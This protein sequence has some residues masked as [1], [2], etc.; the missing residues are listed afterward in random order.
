[1]GII[2][3]LRARAYIGEGNDKEKLEELRKHASV[4]YLI[5]KA[6]PIPTK[7][8]TNGQPIFLAAALP[9]I[10]RVELFEEAINFLQ[11]E[12]PA[13]TKLDIPTM[14]L[15]CFTWLIADDDGNIKPQINETDYI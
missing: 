3:S 2:Y 14:P 11:S 10:N 4:D 12:L 9:A 5:A 6:F 7:F 8:H 1:M 13:Q 15:T